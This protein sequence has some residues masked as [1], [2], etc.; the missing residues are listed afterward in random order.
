MVDYHIH[1]KLCGHASGEIEEYVEKAINKGLQEIGFADH[2]PLSY[3]AKFADNNRLVTM[4]E[5]QIP[6][7][8]NLI[9]KI[10]NKF[11]SIPCKKGF[12]VDYYIN[13]NIFFN[14][15]QKL[16]PETDYI[17]GSVHF[18]DE[19]GFDQPNFK[20][21]I[22][23]VGILN[24]WKSYFTQVKNMINDYHDSIDIIGH[25]DLPKKLFWPLSEEAQEDLNEVIQL[26]T[27]YNLVVEI[28]T[29][30]YDKPIKELYPSL[31]IIKQLYE[32]K[33]E[34]TLGSDAH[35]PNEIARY[36]SKVKEL[37]KQMGYQRLITFTNHKK[38]YINL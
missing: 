34:I 36:F 20:D 22:E 14:S 35:H 10:K 31:D 13:D 30:G 26:I 12:E 21:Q 11:K 16:I 18:L 38:N 25:L 8:L 24:L 3:Q 27:Q 37:L 15:Y 7:Y 19:W 32:K 2:F 9:D 4:T 6:D 5:K 17:I 28:N 33:I 1:T 29:A 23:K